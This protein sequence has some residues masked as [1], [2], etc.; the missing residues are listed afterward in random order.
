MLLPYIPTNDFVALYWFSDSVNEVY[1][2]DKE[3]KK[4]S[5]DDSHFTGSSPAL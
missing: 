2:T 5:S 1:Y 4:R 3:S